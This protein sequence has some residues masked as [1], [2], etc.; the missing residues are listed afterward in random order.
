M[1]QQRV[2]DKERKRGDYTM[3][4]DKLAWVAFLVLLQVGF[5]IFAYMQLKEHYFHVQI[6]LSAISTLAFFALY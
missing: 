6:F 5:I 1:S 3:F 2:I 4:I